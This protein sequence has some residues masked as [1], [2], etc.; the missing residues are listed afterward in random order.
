MVAPRA[1]SPS[2]AIAKTVLVVDDSHLAREA[3]ARL[4]AQAGFLASC[5]QNRAEAELMPLSAVGAV[6]L[7]LE[8]EDADG[9]A[10]YHDLRQRS[11]ELP[12][13]F[14]TGCA[15][16]QKS[17]R[18]PLASPRSF[19]NRPGGTMPLAWAV[20]AIQAKGPGASDRGLSSTPKKPSTSDG[21]TI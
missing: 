18:G 15:D 6:I 1:N 3:T 7:D 17:L 11:A 12:I 9:L 8:L 10:L 14:L 5:V 2:A 21:A 20:N 16:E 13:A 19:G 4:I